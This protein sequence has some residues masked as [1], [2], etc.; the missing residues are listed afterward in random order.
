MDSITF[1]DNNKEYISGDLKVIS[2]VKGEDN[3]EIF[4]FESILLVNW[5]TLYISEK[6]NLAISLL[7]PIKITSLTPNVRIS[8][9]RLFK[10]WIEGS[11]SSYFASKPNANNMLFSTSIDWKEDGLITYNAYVQTDEKWISFK[12]NNEH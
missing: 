5:H 9:M 1:D 6:F 8:N 2:T 7:R 4:K 11:Y 3:V 10:K 12:S